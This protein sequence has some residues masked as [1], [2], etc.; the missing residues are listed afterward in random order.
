MARTDDADDPLF[1][2]AIQGLRRGDFSRLAPLFD[3]GPPPEGRPCRIVAWYDDGCF[4]DDPAALAEA[5]ACACFLGRTGVARF[6]IDRGVDPAAGTATGSNA[7]HWA[8]DRGNLDTVRL[9]IERGAPL[10]AETMYGGTVLGATVW[11]MIHETR[12]DHAAI[13]EALVRA[14]ARLDAS[15]YPTGDDRVDDL[16]R[17]LGAGS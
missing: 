1:R 12:A 7:F 13:I 17:R 2:D 4:D 10:E 16:L 9:L 5:L 3:D 14:G 15:G 11:S 6:L 8:A